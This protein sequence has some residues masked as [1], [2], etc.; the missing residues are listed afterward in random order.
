MLMPVGGSLW[1]SKEEIGMLALQTSDNIETVDIQCIIETVI[2][3]ITAIIH[4]AD[5]AASLSL[6][7]VRQRKSAAKEN[8]RL[9]YCEY[10]KQI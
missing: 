2:L 3:Y 6:P 7:K 4:Y 9:L 8:F 1:V 5:D 10:E